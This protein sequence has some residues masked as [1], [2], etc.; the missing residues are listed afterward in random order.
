MGQRRSSDDASTRL[1]PVARKYTT[2]LAINVRTTSPRM[3]VPRSG[4]KY[5][6]Y[7]PTW[8]GWQS[9]LMGAPESEARAGEEAP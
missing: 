7:S 1:A 8:N 6:T 9:S 2:Q 4:S 5:T 3:G